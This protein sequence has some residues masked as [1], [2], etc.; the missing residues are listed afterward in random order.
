MKT[1]LSLITKLA[2][3]GH[4]TLSFELIDSSLPGTLDIENGV[5]QH[6]APSGTRF[7]VVKTVAFRGSAYHIAL[8]EDGYRWMSKVWAD[9]NCVQVTC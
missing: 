7:R 3:P 9:E 8:G 1:R 4:P 6:V 5:R 2:H